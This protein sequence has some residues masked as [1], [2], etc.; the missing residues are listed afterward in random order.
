MKCS[1]CNKD[2]SEVDRIIK[3]DNACIC[4]KCVLVSLRIIL[5]PDLDMNLQ[6]R[7]EELEK[8]VEQIM[9]TLE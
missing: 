9:P 1:F 2:R 7:V 3:A 8:K 6:V 4:D 5:F